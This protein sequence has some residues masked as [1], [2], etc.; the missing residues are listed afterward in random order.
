[1]LRHLYSEVTKLSDELFTPGDEVYPVVWP[2]VRRSEWYETRF[3]ELGLQSLSSFYELLEQAMEHKAEY[4]D[5]A[6]M[7]TFLKDRDFAR[8]LLGLRDMFQKIG[9]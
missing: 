6:D 8:V 9:V 5:E 7:H 2:V 3:T 4:G 1:M